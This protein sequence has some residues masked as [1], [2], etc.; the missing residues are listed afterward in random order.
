MTHFAAKFQAAAQRL[1]ALF[2]R[3][4]L[5]ADE[6]SAGAAAGLRNKSLGRRA[7]VAGLAITAAFL[8]VTGGV[9]YAIAYQ[10]AQ[11]H[12]DDMLDEAAGILARVNVAFASAPPALEVLTMDDADFE[13][14]H[15]LPPSDP[16]AMLDAG[17]QLLILTLHKSGRGI[18]VQL[19]GPLY[20]G[21][22]N[23]TVNGRVYRVKFLS[24]STGSRI[25]VGEEQDKV[26]HAAAEETLR[27]ITP[28]VIVATVFYVLLALFFWRLSSP[29]RTIAAE[30][31]RRSG[32]TLKP[33]DINDVP[34]EI[35]PLAQA[36]NDLFGRVDELRRQEARFVA[37]AAHELRSPLTALSLQAE[38]M[39]KDDM[40]PEARE[41]LKKLRA[42]IARAAELV[43]QL[44]AL[45]RAQ[46]QA[47][48]PVQSADALQEVD[49]HE[50]LSRVIQDVWEEMERKGIELHV[51][52]LDDEPARF[53]MPAGDL[54]TVLR[55][56]LE[57]AVRY[58]ASDAGADQPIVAVRAVRDPAGRIVSLTVA[59]NG[60][61]IAESD[62]SRIFDAFYRVLGTGVSG[63]GLGLAI[64]QTL[65][66]RH[67]LRVHVQDAD[68]SAPEGRR[69]AAF[70]IEPDPAIKA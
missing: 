61:G 55:N 7:A 40:S 9:L 65:C 64:V 18:Q 47:D 52:G 13:A 3:F 4:R 24:L 45:K 29:V 67:G 12:Q 59:D 11:D 33:L 41:K 58:A 53:P 42:G 32:E 6:P 49:L 21:I 69:G 20:V 60:P 14:R 2:R 1:A 8:F 31:S 54:F 68:P 43:S 28:I 15:E 19:A 27:A 70:T 39:E 35:L 57:N 16:R 44:L 48:N 38:R 5:R 26:L 23:L 36:L 37:D 63:T 51:E 25:V 66:R 30:V 46:A 56:L 50:V 62:K 22:S 34:T 10:S 17:E